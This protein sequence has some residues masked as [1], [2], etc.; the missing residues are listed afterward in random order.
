MSQ[1]IAWCGAHQ[2]HILCPEVLGMKCAMQVDKKTCGAEDCVVFLIISNSCLF[3]D[4][5]KEKQNKR[6]S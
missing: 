4:G 2:A 6:V 1:R 3:R 5:V